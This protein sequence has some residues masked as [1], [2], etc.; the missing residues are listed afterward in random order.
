GHTLGVVRLAARLA[1]ALLVAALAAG[2]GLGSLPAALAQSGGPEPPSPGP[3]FVVTLASD[4]G[5]A[6]VGDGFCAT[7][8]GGCTLR[9][10]IEEA[11]GYAGP[12]SITFSID[13]AG[14]A[15]IA[16]GTPL[17]SITDT[18]AIDGYTQP[19]SAEN[20]DE[21]STSA[22]LAVHLSGGADCSTSE[23][24][25]GLHFAA[26]SN[27]SSVRGL[28]IGGFAGDGILVE[29]AFGVSILGTFIG[30]EADGS[31]AHPNCGDGL[32]AEGGS[33]VQVGDGSRTGR[34]VVSAN[35]GHGI[36][37]VGPGLD[38]MPAGPVDIA[39]NLI[40]LASDGTTP[41][42]N[43]LDGVRIQDIGA[44]GGRVG[45]FPGD[46]LGWARSNFI[47][48]NGGNGVAVDGAQGVIV[49]GNTIGL[50]V[51]GSVVPN[52]LA[53]VAV[54]G[55]DDEVATGLNSIDG[56]GGLGIDLKADGEPA[57]APAVTGNDADDSDD[58]PSFLL[59][60]PELDGL[61]DADGETVVAGR[62][63]VEAGRS[64]TILLYHVPQCDASGHGEGRTLLG[65]TGLFG[66]EVGTEMGFE[67]VAD[68]ASLPEDGALTALALYDG[69]GADTA[70]S[71]FSGCLALG[72]PPDL[73]ID[74][75]ERSLRVNEKGRFQAIASG[76]FPQDAGL[77]W[78]FG[79]GV[80][81]DD[82][83]DEAEHRW[84]SPGDRDVTAVV[85]DGDGETELA[86]AEAAVHVVAAA[87]TSRFR[88]EEGFLDGPCECDALLLEDGEGGDGEGGDGGGGELLDP[89]RVQVGEPLLFTEDSF[90]GG[91]ALTFAWTFGDGAD[92]TEGAVLHAYETI[93]DFPVRLTTRD[94]TGFTR[95]V[96]RTVHAIDA[97]PFTG[98]VDPGGNVSM[99]L[100]PYGTLT[101]A[102]G[103]DGAG[104][105]FDGF[106]VLA[107][108][109]LGL[110]DGFGPLAGTGV[111]FVSFIGGPAPGQCDQVTITLD[112]D[113]TALGGW[114]PYLRAYYWTGS[115]WRDLLA[116]GPGGVIP[117]AD[118]EDDLHVFSYR[119]DAAGDQA[120]FVTDHTSS[121]ALGVPPLGGGGSGPAAPAPAAPAPAPAPAAPAP[122][123]PGPGP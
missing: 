43:G 41:L 22:V 10:A 14:V 83:D 16:P 93:G 60:F 20:E 1:T 79:D 5:D 15:T 54:F 103:V 111:L 27:G 105:D 81:D 102:V 34:N 51:E 3:P 56:N 87:L 80:T 28:A 59:N 47:A 98:H 17:P 38:A 122:A 57:D 120:T 110:D 55:A 78:S 31:T 70:G 32:H 77:T 117:G 68:V 45:A 37:L 82:G 75:P 46:D 90:G 73:A 19:G 106:V 7:T 84:T 116:Y 48:G 9:A 119:L 64:L 52:E 121:Y 113:P 101:C 53:G 88:V 91:G 115:T 89:I 74:P 33:G 67:I 58:G 29:G 61:V 112:Y 2:G 39:G 42:G 66:S 65:S 72:A 95:M 86:S 23:I 30:T 123:A 97:V 99:A 18:V 6:S 44:V 108:G 40:G 8:G 69:E 24:A 62:A 50:D 104:A 25:P 94:A 85:L 12:D 13:T 76:T 26:G 21:G 71:E 100:D 11:N 4:E 36:A 118:P 35:G 107:G 49:V 114:E 63:F 92:S 109:P 96:Q